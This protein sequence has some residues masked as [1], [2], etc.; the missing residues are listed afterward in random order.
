MNLKIAKKIISAYKMACS[1]GVPPT[2]NFDW[3]PSPMGYKMADLMLAC[4]TMGTSLEELQKESIPKPEPKPA[5]KK[6]VAKKPAPK[7]AVAK[8]PA[9]KKVEVKAQEPAPKKVEPKKEVKVAPAP[10]KEEPKAEVKTEVKAEVKKSAPKKVEIKAEELKSN[11]PFQDED[12]NGIL[13]YKEKSTTSRKRTTK[14][15]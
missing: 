9:P 15:K 3:Q 6:V 7:K 5:P 8:K 13:D 2:T 10:K 1:D 14:K 11:N 4:R 12:N